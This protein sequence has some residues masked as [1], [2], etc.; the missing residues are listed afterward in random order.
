MVNADL[1]QAA[2]S[3]AYE[4]AFVE[5]TSPIRPPEDAPGVEVLRDEDGN[6]LA[7]SWANAGQRFLHVVGVAVFEWSRDQHRITAAAPPDVPRPSVTAAFHKNVVPLL[8]YFAGY[9]VL[10]AS[11]VRSAAGIVGF[12]ADAGTGKSTLAY[13]LGTRGFPQWADDALAID[14]SRERPMALALPF[15]SRLR[16]RAR[17]FFHG[18]TPFRASDAE[19]PL[20][21]LGL[22]VRAPLEDDVVRLEKLAGGRAFDEVVQHAYR[23]GLRTDHDRRRALIENYL[24]LVAVVPVYE[25]RFRPGFES[26]AAVV[27]IVGE[28]LADEVGRAV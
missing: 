10:H 11:A 20:A 4:L 6:A 15:E 25:I 8:H 17:E 13:G 24:R 2:P 3:P 27:E 9:E 7:I 23:L 16:S 1:A 19:A 14:L 5:V 28:R 22:I 18:A 12:C 21:A 26:L